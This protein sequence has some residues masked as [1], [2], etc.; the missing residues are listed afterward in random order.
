MGN[1]MNILRLVSL[2]TLLFGANML[3]AQ[4]IQTAVVKSTHMAGKYVY[5]QTDGK[6]NE[7]WLATTA[8]PVK[9]GDTVE[10]LG[11]QLMTN[12]PSKAL[13]RTFERI[14]FVSHLRVAGSDVPFDTSSPHSAAPGAHPKLVSVR[15]N[16]VQKLDGGKTVAEV[17]SEAEQLN[18]KTLRLR[19]KV[20][21]VSRQ[22]LGKNWLTLKD[23]SGSAPN[24]KLVVTTQEDAQPGDLV[25]VEGVAHTQVELGS[26]YSYPILLEQAKLSPGS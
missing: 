21:K 14:L 4:D 25:I 16:E 23:G 2:L 5:I 3:A 9:A 12:F 8:L 18:G 6:N 26:G 13:D 22:I 19:A 24:D 11:G 15:P 10:Y 17:L 20:T 7:E 1:A